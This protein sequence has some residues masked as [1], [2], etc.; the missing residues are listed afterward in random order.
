MYSDSTDVIK[1]EENGNNFPA[2]SDADSANHN[3]QPYSGD[4]SQVAAIDLS[5]DLNNQS[6]ARIICSSQSEAV[7]PYSQSDK[8]KVISADNGEFVRES[9][10]L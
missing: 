3:T 4:Q 8:N 9:Q 5:A 6:E 7:D 1:L 2:K 10:L